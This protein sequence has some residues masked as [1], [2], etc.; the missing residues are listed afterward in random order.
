MKIASI[1][2]VIFLD[3]PDNHRKMTKQN[4][5]NMKKHLLGCIAL[6]GT[7]NSVYGQTEPASSYFI[8]TDPDGYVN[9]RDEPSNTG[10]I[11]EAV[12]SL[13]VVEFDPLREETGDWIYCRYG[14]LSNSSNFGYIH[15]SRLT[16]V[17]PETAGLIFEYSR[18]WSEVY[19]LSTEMP[20]LF[21]FREPGNEIIE[22]RDLNRDEFVFGIGVPVCLVPIWGDTINFCYIFFDQMDVPQ[23]RLRPLFAHYKPYRKPDG[24]YDLFTEILP[25]PWTVSREEARRIVN[26]L[27]VQSGFPSTRDCIDLFTAYCSGEEEAL[28]ILL[29]APCD[30]SLCHEQDMFLSAMDAWRRS[31]MK[32]L[33]QPR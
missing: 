14:I 10:E 32:P 25:E 28:T 12:R 18:G 20:E 5:I 7:I 16:P 27:R 22:V 9:V 15:R 13:S 24:S 8:V 3:R 2:F 30:A 19:A 1:L 26:R 29:A 11:R 21:L 17:N 23:T 4:L 6:L 33:S 31:K